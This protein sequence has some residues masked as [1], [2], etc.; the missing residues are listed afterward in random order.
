MIWDHRTQKMYW[1][2]HIFGSKKKRGMQSKNGLQNVR[3]YCVLH[4]LLRN[5]MS[6]FIKIFSL[7][8]TTSL[9]NLVVEVRTR[10]SHQILL[11]KPQIHNNT[12]KQRQCHKLGKTFTGPMY[13]LHLSFMVFSDVYSSLIPNKLHLL[14]TVSLGGFQSSPEA[15]KS[16]E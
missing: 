1:K 16:T 6:L 14:S 8:N 2:P 11:L 5:L 12:P 4:S 13:K 15:L 9:A 7:Y 3:E 10:H